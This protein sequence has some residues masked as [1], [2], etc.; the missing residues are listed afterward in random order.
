[1]ALALAGLTMA[2]LVEWAAHAVAPA[3]TEPGVV[4][5]T[6]G[7][8]DDSEGPEAED[9]TIAAVLDS[10]QV[11]DIA[12]YNSEGLRE[13]VGVGTPVLVTRSHADGQVLGV[14]AP[15]G[16]VDTHDFAGSWF[17]RGF[18]VLGL[19]CGLAVGLR[20]RRADRWWAVAALA[21]SAVAFS[22]WIWTGPELDRTFLLPD[23]M[24]TYA[25]ELPPQVAIGVP[26]RVQE[27]TVT[28]RGT[29]TP[30]LP[31]GA[32][33]ALAGFETFTVPLTTRAEESRYV[34][35]ELIGDGAGRAELLRGFPEPACGG[36]PGALGEDIP[37]GT[38]DVVLCAV[39]PT[40]FQP[41]YLVLGTAG[42]DQ[43]ALRLG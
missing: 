23:G 1:V 4:A 18:A 27:V 5:S 33:P 42:P 14:R 37:A 41:R 17:L 11:L 12:D 19:A 9:F 15:T 32:D 26:V 16:Y 35:M 2:F 22:A 40:G 25:D 34:K 13:A 28:V 24:W 38:A 8:Y 30:G 20:A 31:P 6:D 3:T 7:P 10:G 29:P 43:V 36:A 21:G 39:V